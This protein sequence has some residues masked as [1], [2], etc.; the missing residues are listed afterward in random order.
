M[1]LLP[2]DGV[3]SR[4]DD[5]KARQARSVE[6]RRDLL[7]AVIG[8]EVQQKS[9]HNTG[10]DPEL[11]RQRG[12]KV[13]INKPGSGESNTHPIQIQVLFTHIYLGP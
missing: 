3:E 7:P 6:P 2:G 1:V 4:G 13:I 8:K 9:A 12:A 10:N 11:W 5:E